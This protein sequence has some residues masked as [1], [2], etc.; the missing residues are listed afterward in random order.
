MSKWITGSI[1][2]I[3]TLWSSAVQC[4]IS[5]LSTINQYWLGFTTSFSMKPPSFWKSRWGIDKWLLEIVIMWRYQIRKYFVLILLT[6]VI[7]NFTLFPLWKDSLST[8][9]RSVWTVLLRKINRR[10][11][12]L[13]IVK[14]MTMWLRQASGTFY[15]FKEACSS[16][17]IAFVGLK[18]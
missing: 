8:F 4:L 2:I 3:M 12:I 18:T 7:V 9:I 14:E 10:D 17:F 13:A 6:I 11:L 16:L 1:V 15:K 5:D